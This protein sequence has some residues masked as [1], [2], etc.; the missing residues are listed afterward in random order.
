MIPSLSGGIYQFDGDSI[1]PIPITADN[2]LS[3]SFKFSDDLVISGGKETRSYGVSK[4]SG[5]LLY[6]CSMHGC[7]NH[8]KIG[9]EDED[10]NNLLEHNPTID[11]VIV[12]RRQTQTVR[13]IEPRS[14]LERWNFSVGHHELEL[15]KSENCH[16]NIEKPL[17]IDF[18][19]KIVVPDGIVCAVDKRN[20][21]QILWKQKVLILI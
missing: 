10:E 12:I 7:T 4:N 9:E 8:T 20:P 16:T 15:I 11:D 2:L 17:D 19:I 13:A 21:S 1:E 14:G 6:E 3:S 5:K 18:E